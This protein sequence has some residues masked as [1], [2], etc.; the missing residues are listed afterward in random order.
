[1]PE[2]STE[3]YEKYKKFQKKGQDRVARRKAERQ[4]LAAHKDEVT[5]AIGK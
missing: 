4:V 3:E 5:A 1:M 2:I